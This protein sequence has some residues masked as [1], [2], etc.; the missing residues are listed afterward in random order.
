ME[1]SGPPDKGGATPTAPHDRPRHN[2][3][4]IWISALLAVVAAGLAIWAL[5]LRSDRD[6]TQQQLDETKQALTTTEQ[7]LDTTKQQLATAQ[8][9]L[10]DLQ[11]SQR[12]RTGLALLTGK[13]LYDK[14]AAELGATREELAETQQDVTNAEQ[15][16]TQ[17]EQDAAAAEQDAADADTE[18]D[19]AKAE[20]NQ[21]KAESRAAQSKAD[22]AKGCARAYIEAFGGLFDGD[23]A[24]AQAATVRKD[25]Q[26]V[27][28]GCKA[29]LADTQSEK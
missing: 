9:D 24:R 25:L 22:A 14:F 27:T 28:A 8:Q 5:T 17:A 4:W 13:V 29:T 2:R 12:R 20:A 3:R 26:S 19:K 16:G 18:I 23:D 6:D 10:E 11:T 21:A 15:A 7:Q 1:R